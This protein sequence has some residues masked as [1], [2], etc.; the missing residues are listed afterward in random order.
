MLFHVGL[1]SV[2]IRTGQ[3]SYRINSQAVQPVRSCFSHQKQPFHRERPHFFFNFL[4][5]QGMYQIRFFE[6]PGH[7][8]QK[9]VAGHTDVYGE[10]QFL[11]DLILQLPG[12]FHRI[13]IKHLIA[14]KIRPG[15]INAVLDHM[16]GIAFQQRYQSLRIFHI[17]MEIRRDNDQVRAFLPG[18]HYRL[19]CL[20]PIFLGRRALGK[21]NTMASLL[22]A[23][24][25]GRHRPQVKLLS[26]HM[27]TVCRAPA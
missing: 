8:G 12:K 1:Q 10:A 13:P 11:P 2:H 25:N 18:C 27:A 4:R 14:G 9:A 23:A 22:I 19:P 15:F 3:I 17:Q 5:E 26:Q 20:N 16:V 21:H 6:I 7:F 24:H